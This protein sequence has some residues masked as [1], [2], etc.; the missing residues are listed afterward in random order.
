MLIILWVDF[1]LLHWAS[2]RIPI[3][4]WLS[5]ML[6]HI[7]WLNL[8]LIVTIGH[9]QSH[10]WLC[11]GL[12]F[13]LSWLDLNSSSTITLYNYFHS[14]SWSIESDSLFLITYPFK[15]FW[16]WCSSPRLPRGRWWK[17]LPIIFHIMW[18]GR[19]IPHVKYTRTVISL[20]Y[21]KFLIPPNQYGM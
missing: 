12:I 10:A 1:I 16:L 13:F 17:T 11:L 15:L 4:N 9:V 20:Y 8:W 7:L 19:P 6:C 18:L 21:Q 3:H 5:C 14:W 2:N